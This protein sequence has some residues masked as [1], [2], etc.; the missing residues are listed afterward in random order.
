MCYLYQNAFLIG[1]FVTIA[2]GII[3]KVSTYP[4]W[5]APC[6]QLASVPFA[7]GASPLL[8][9]PFSAFMPM[10]STLE[11][12]PIAV[13]WLRLH[14]AVL[15]HLPSSQQ[16]GVQIL[17]WNQLE[18]LLVTV[19]AKEKAPS[20]RSVE[21]QL[22][23]GNMEEL[24]LWANLLAWSSEHL[25]S[26]ASSGKPVYSSFALHTPSPRLHFPHLQGTSRPKNATQEAFSILFLWEKKMKSSLSITYGRDIYLYIFIYNF[27]CGWK[28]QS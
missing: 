19:W 17:S 28:S 3:L 7:F 25:R 24:G 2:K 4:Q 9:N 10:Y 20:G 8:T 1:G 27:F 22:P 5:S 21:P 11:H 15:N 23:L 13:R 6:L 14:L 12:W 18:T 16:P 26:H